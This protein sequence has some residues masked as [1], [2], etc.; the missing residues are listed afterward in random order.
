M[1]VQSLQPRSAGGAVAPH[2]HLGVQTASPVLQ[3][4]SGQGTKC[5]N[6]A[7]ATRE[8]FWL[9]REGAAPVWREARG[10]EG[11]RLEKQVQESSWNAPA[12]PWEL[13]TWEVCV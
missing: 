11:F 10:S 3:G 12:Q 1:L 13:G 4:S 9:Q 6:T 2:D 8:L 5:R 7:Q